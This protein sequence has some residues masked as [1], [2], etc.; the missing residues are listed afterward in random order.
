MKRQHIIL[1]LLL[2]LWGKLQAQCDSNFFRYTATYINDVALIDTARMIGVGDNGLIIRTIDGGRHWENIHTYQTKI[3]RTI[4]MFGDSVGYVAGSSRTLLKTEDGGKSWISIDANIF[5]GS[6]NPDFDY[7]GLFFL[8]SRRGFIIGGWGKI[9]KTVDGGRSWTDASIDGVTDGFS[10][11]NF[12]NDSTGFVCGGNSI[13]YKTVDT[14]RTWQKIELSLLGGIA[15]SLTKVKFISSTTGFIVGNGGIFLKTTDGGTNWSFAFPL[16]N[17][18]YSDIYFKDAQSG[19]VI[20]VNG[21]YGSYYTTTDGGNTWVAEPTSEL[22]A[23]GILSINADANGQKI[24][25]AGGLLGGSITGTNGRTLLATTNLGTSYHTLSANVKIPYYDAFFLNDSTGYL[26]GGTNSVF[27]TVDYG[28]SWIPLKNAHVYFGSNNM[29]R[30]FF[31]DVLNGY[32]SSD[33][34]SK[35]TDGGV[36]WTKLPNPDNQLQYFA[37]QLYFFN[38]LT[39]LV[40]DNTTIYKTTTGGSAWTKVL[41]APSVLKD[42]TFIGNGKGFAV[43]TNGI[44]YVTTNYGDTWTPQTVNA[45]LQ[46]TSIYFYNNSLGFIGTST[47]SLYRTTDGGINWTNISPVGTFVNFATRS[48]KFVAETV[49]YFLQ[50]DN[51]GTSAIYKTTDGGLTWKMFRSSFEN[52]YDLAGVKTVYATGRDGLI[53][54]TDTLQKPPAPGYIVGPVKACVG[55][56]STYVTGSLQG[57]DFNWVLSSGGTNSYIGNRDTVLWNAAGLHT[58]SVT[59]SNACGL[60]PARQI[61]VET[62]LF[63]PVIS[64]QDSVLT[65]TE[66]VSYEWFRNGSAIA[67]GQGGNSRSLVGRQSGSYTVKVKSFYGCTVIS[68][69]VSYSATVARIICPGTITSLASNL[70]ASTYQWQMDD[71]SGFVN[72]TNN[73][74]FVGATAS[75]LQLRA[76]VPS[77]W[78]GYKFR[79]VTNLG[80]SDTYRLQFQNTWTGASN[81]LWENTANWSCGKVPDANT[82]VVINSGNIII[83]SNVIIRKLTLGMGVNLTVGSGYTLTVTH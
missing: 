5:S 4:Q 69:A 65:A 25:F 29:Q 64:V 52:V 61:I 57:H 44:L 43:S 24:I 7:N 45:S 41:D 71:S 81:T 74:Y 51:T 2:G 14:G 42:F 72:I 36:N 9:L 34:I 31:L 21:S 63:Q 33:L 68:P 40:M 23:S 67:A 16:N 38:A 15:R 28:E 11:I 3:L 78:Y 77:S 58:L 26:A 48:F 76:T 60:S 66:G 75:F 73:I 55:D 79:C 80:M 59:A 19:I 62:I 20:G 47:N 22:P 27:K 32:A 39:G 1:L 18:T 12:A 8:N 10:D 56:E 37:K 46:L 54:K 82:D 53:I 6:F 49:G 70:S 35:T 83:S 17:G 30:V 50:N 13:L